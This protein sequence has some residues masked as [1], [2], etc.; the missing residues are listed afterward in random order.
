M[1]VFYLLFQVLKVQDLSLSLMPRVHLPRHPVLRLESSGVPC[2]LLYL[3]SILAAPSTA[4][5]QPLAG[6][7]QCQE[8]QHCLHCS[9]HHPRATAAALCQEQ[10]LDNSGDEAKN[11]ANLALQRG[12]DTAHLK[13]L[14]CSTLLFLA[15]HLSACMA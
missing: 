11:L 4:Q 7:A 14:L 8:E 5:T 13:Q 15:L 6:D 3:P 2:G 12:T 10:P 1:T 9:W